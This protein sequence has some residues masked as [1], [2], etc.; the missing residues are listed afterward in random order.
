MSH[1]VAS[2]T[3]IIDQ[4]ISMEAQSGGY[5]GIILQRNKKVMR[6]KTIFDTPSY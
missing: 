5:F 4:L 1:F 3:E 6:T 2:V